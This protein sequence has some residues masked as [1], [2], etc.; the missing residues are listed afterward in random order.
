M[1]LLRQLQ[2]HPLPGWAA[3]IDCIS[4]AQ[5]ALKFVV[6]HPAVTCAIPATRNIAHVRE[7]M[8]A[9]RGRQPDAALRQRMAEQVR[10]L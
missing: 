6:S 8:D 4:W 3:E 2:R 9:A 1:A 5:V 7:N 10:R